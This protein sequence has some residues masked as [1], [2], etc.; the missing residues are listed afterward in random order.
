MRTDALAGRLSQ[1]RA[2]LLFDDQKTFERSVLAFIGLGLGAAVLTNSFGRSPGYFAALLLAE[3]AILFAP[4]VRGSD[5]VSV[6]PVRFVL[7]LVGPALAAFGDPAQGAVVAAA[8]FGVTLTRD[9]STRLKLLVPLGTGLSMVWA[10]AVANL[11]DRWVLTAVTNI[12]RAGFIGTALG[13]L[14]AMGVLMAHLKWVDPV[15]GKLWSVPG[16]Q[17][18]N[19]LYQRCRKALVLSPAPVVARMLESVTLEAGQ[20]SQQL[21]T[22]DAAL[23]KLDRAEAEKE[24]EKVRVLLETADGRSREGLRSAE[25][26]WSDALEHMDAL[27]TA[28]ARLEANLLARTAWLERAALGLETVH[29]SELG[30]LAERLATQ[31]PE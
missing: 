16:A 20:L 10:L 4:Q 23:A 27:T 31:R 17:K 28:R 29:S 8:L 3:V 18:L 2:H 19:G 30:S 5:A 1:V 25:L 9:A 7:S 12:A 26:S 21:V 13:L 6:L 24:L 11:Y 14:S 22:A 15:E